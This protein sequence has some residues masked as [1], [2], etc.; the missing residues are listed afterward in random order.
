MKRD[1]FRRYVWLVDVIR[2]A[3]SITYEEISELWKESPLNTDHSPLAL[4]TFHN[5]REAIHQLFGIRILCNRSD[6]EYY[7]QQEGSHGSETKLRVWMLQT[8]ALQSLASQDGDIDDRIMLDITPEEKHGLAAV[9]EAMRTNNVI[10]IRYPEINCDS[11]RRTTVV[12]EPYC[13]RFWHHDWYLL[14][15]NTDNDKLEV[16][17]LGSVL[18]VQILDRKFSY[19]AGFSPREF[20]R[21]YFGVEGDDNREPLNIRVRI[22]GDNRQVLRL[23][24]LHVSQR[25]VLTEPDSSIFDY[26][27]VPSPKFIS[28]ILSLGPKAEIIAPASLRQEMLQTLHK[29]LSLYE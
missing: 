16:Y 6:H 2:N 11:V 10:A 21:N 28:Y 24:P 7:I 18:Q 29:M 3:K 19:P 1:L 13:L 9:F 5:H 20:F 8:L 12:L 26:L 22:K 23:N 25:E 17:P 14:G 27:L 4:R 15:K